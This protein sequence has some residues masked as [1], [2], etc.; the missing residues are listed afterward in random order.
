MEE[1][2]EI[3]AIDTE[4]SEGVGA[5]TN[6][7][8]FGRFKDLKSLL[9]AYDNLQS[10]F[11]RRCQ[12]VKTLERESELLKSENESLKGRF[13][14]Q[15]GANSDAKGTFLKK[16]PDAEEF[17][18]SLDIAS[19]GEGELTVD[20]LEKSYVE[21]L[22]GEINALK[23]QAESEDDL[24]SL[25]D[26]KPKV[27]ER[28]IKSYLEQVDGFKPKVNLSVGS[29]VSVTAPPHKPKTL[30]DAGELALKYFENKEY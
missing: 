30:Q 16:Y 20:F 28:I 23:T 4:V 29:G 6:E 1:K 21:K 17:Y 10:E 24:F 5:S 14:E 9:S 13:A 3:A 18:N 25:I 19:V 7:T 26:K 12:R 15:D 22:K 2:N 8:S 27:R 11:T